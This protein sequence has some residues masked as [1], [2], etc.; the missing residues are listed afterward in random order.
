MYKNFLSISALYV[1]IVKNK[2]YKYNLTKKIEF[3]RLRLIDERDWLMNLAK[4]DFE[5]KNNELLF[6]SLV[7]T[8]NRNIYNLLGCISIFWNLST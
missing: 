6:L 8:K 5:K 2:E 7:Y 4:I 3:E 1:V